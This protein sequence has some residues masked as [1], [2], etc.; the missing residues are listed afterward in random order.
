MSQVSEG[1]MK[2]P[3]STSDNFVVLRATLAG[4]QDARPA[5]A[6]L[7]MAWERSVV[8]ADGGAI[9]EQ[10]VRDGGSVHMAAVL[11]CVSSD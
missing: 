1:D 8:W 3:G 9:R 11:A 10:H 2:D 4:G 6:S 7:A 5:P